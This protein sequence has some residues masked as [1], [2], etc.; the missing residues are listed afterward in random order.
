MSPPIIVV[1]GV[2]GSGKSTVGRRLAARMGA[3]FLEG[4]DLHTAEAITKMRSGVPLD[5][6]DRRPWIAAVERR[7]DVWLGAGQAGVVACSALRRSYRDDL[8]R[9]R[10]ELAI[11][12]LT[13][14]VAELRRRLEARRGHFMPAALLDSQIATLEPVSSDETRAFEISATSSPDATA[15]AILARLQIT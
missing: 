4:D 6:A 8:R 11:A 3:E 1:A 13:A 2:S 5:D 7:I 12:V 9:G 14:P 10:P 15:V